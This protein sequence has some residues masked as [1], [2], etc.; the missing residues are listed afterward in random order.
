MHQE[1]SFGDIQDALIGASASGSPSEAH[2]ML[3]GMLC[4]DLATDR[5]QWLGDFFGPELADIHDHYRA[6]LCQLFEQTRR[7]LDDFDFSF[8]PLLP[9]EDEPLVTRAQA[10]SEWCHGFLQGLGYTGQNTAWP[11][12][13]ADILNDLLEIVRL[14]SS[15]TDETDESA[16]TELAEYVRVAVQVIQQELVSQTSQ[17]RH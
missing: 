6:Q 9:D 10:L 12:E 14:D 16:Y 11:G 1:V 4:V 5:E 2:G 15:L 7:Q 17:Q 3:S 13:S 8:Q